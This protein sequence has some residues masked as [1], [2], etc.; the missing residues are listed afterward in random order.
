MTA[1]TESVAVFGK[2]VVV[3]AGKQV[4]VIVGNFVVPGKPAVAA[5]D[6]RLVAGVE[7]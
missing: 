3:G 7:T 1:G 6:I 2:I 5:A 4:V